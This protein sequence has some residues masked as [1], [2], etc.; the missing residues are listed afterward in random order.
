MIIDKKIKVKTNPSN[1][2]YYKEKGYIIN[3]CGEDV[4]IDVNDLP[5]KST[6]KINCK[7][8]NCGIDRLITY[9]NY[10]I[11]TKI[12]NKDVCIKC[13]GEK[14]KLTSKKKYGKLFQ[15]TLEFKEK[16]KGINYEKYGGKE[17][18][19]KFISE[20]SKQKCQE[21]Y[22][23]NSVMLLKEY[24]NKSKLGMLNKYG[25]EYPMQNE[26][27]FNKAQK[28]GLRLKEYNGLKYQG[29]YE[30]DF[31]KFCE[32]NNIKVE[33]GKTIKFI[34]HSQNK[35]YYPD[36]YLPEYNLICEIKS[37]YYYQKYLN[38][39]I[40]KEKTAIENGFNFKFIINKN[41]D[42]LMIYIKS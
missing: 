9:S 36:Y 2:K 6:V 37:D 5:P 32:K 22:G 40:L 27:S 8:D 20:I 18:Y 3:K 39:N 11:A 4:E 42:S 17:G 41:Y 34:M 25:V 15:S 23:V 31:L 24:Q 21:K 38:K 16:I 7:C 26:F 28:T 14:S 33:R 29:T 19:S 1:Y 13:C 30:L 12:N 35:I 10:T